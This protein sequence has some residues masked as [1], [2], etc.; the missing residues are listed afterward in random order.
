M[1]AFYGRFAMRRQTLWTLLLLMILVGAPLPKRLAAQSAA[2]APAQQPATQERPAQ[3]APSD[4]K[5]VV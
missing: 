3:P 4:R 1:K 2:E 5:S